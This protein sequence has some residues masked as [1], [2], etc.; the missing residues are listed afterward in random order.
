MPRGD[1]VAFSIG[2][3]SWTWRELGD[4]GVYNPRAPKLLEDALEI[5]GVDTIGKFSLINPQE[6]TRIVGDETGFVSLHVYAH[7]THKD[8]IR[9]ISRGEKPVRWTT[10]KR[11]MKKQKRRQKKVA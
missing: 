10:Y 6:I 4:M 5:L 2:S 11:R 3:R 9:W 1:R 8:P 7:V